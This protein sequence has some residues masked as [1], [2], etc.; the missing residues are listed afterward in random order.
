[1]WHKGL[2]LSDIAPAYLYAYQALCIYFQFSF[3]EPLRY[4]RDTGVLEMYYRNK[5]MLIAYSYG[6]NNEITK[7]ICKQ[8]GLPTYGYF[9][10]NTF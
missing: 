6:W 8:L 5:W 4:I 2:L 10:M 3:T 7:L 9:Y 1:M